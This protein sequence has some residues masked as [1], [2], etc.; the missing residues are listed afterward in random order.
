[1]KASAAPRRTLSSRLF[2]YDLF[3]SFALGPPPRGSRNYASDLARKL[4][5]RDFT[6]FFSED[7]APV[8]GKLDETLKRALH[9][10][11]V[12]VVVA[13]RGTL[14]NP[15]WV[16]QEVDEY[17]RRHPQRLVVPIN[18]D[19][20]LQDSQLAA[21]T[22]GWLPF[23]DRIWIDETAAAAEAGVASDEVVDRLVTAP[24]SVRAAVRWRWLVGAIIFFLAGLAAAAVWSALEA[25]R[26]RDMAV[27]RQLAVHAERAPTAQEAVLLAAESLHLRTFAETEALLRE[28]LALLPRV[29]HH[30][31]LPGA[32]PEGVAPLWPV[33]A[34]SPRGTY[35]AATKNG[36]PLHVIDVR[37]GRTVLRQFDNATRAQFSAGEDALAV[38][39]NSRQAWLVRLP[40][41]SARKIVDG[42]GEVAGF[43][44]SADGRRLLVG[45][46]TNYPDM[47]RQRNGFLVID[48]S[49]GERLASVRAGREVRRVALSPDGLTAYAEMYG[50]VAAWRAVDPVSGPDTL[51]KGVRQ[52]VPDPQ[53]P[54]VLLLDDQG[55]LQRVGAADPTEGRWNQTGVEAFV[56]SEDGDMLAAAM[57]GAVVVVSRRDGGFYERLGRPAGAPARSLQFL[58][59]GSLLRI[60]QTLYELPV[61]PDRPDRTE[62]RLA[63]TLLA[64]AATERVP[65]AWNP[66]GT[67][68]ATVE[69]PTGLPRI[70]F[71]QTRAGDEVARLRHPEVCRLQ[72]SRDGER[73]LSAGADGYARVWDWQRE[74]LIASVEHPFP[75]HAA[76]FAPDDASVV[77]LGP[78]GGRWWQASDAARLGG[79]DRE[80]PFM[81]CWSDPPASLAWVGH[82]PL[83][84]LPETL[85]RAA[86]V[87]VRNG[88][89]RTRL[90]HPAGSE[91][92]RDWYRLQALLAPDASE[93][94]TFNQNSPEPLLLHRLSDSAVVPLRLDPPDFPVGYLA[95]TDRHELVAWGRK[96]LDE[97]MSQRVWSLSSGRAASAAAGK[98]VSFT[99]DPR[100]LVRAVDNEAL[101]QS[102]FA[103]G[104]RA[105]ARSLDE[106]YLAVQ[107]GPDIRI[108][109]TRPEDLVQM[110][111]K[112]TLRAL[113]DDEWRRFM[114][115]VPPRPACVA[116]EK[117]SVR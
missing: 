60:D 115:T 45:L 41:G 53:G 102:L 11:G 117:T 46:Q 49:S 31:P 97:P 77:S 61:M 16:R 70:Q 82:D 24:S 47:G 17:R 64:L 100:G 58:A 6:V 93:A 40:D 104:R 9:R 67:L 95:F 27:A 109:S 78:R 103:H 68:L 90:Q 20:A 80:M 75:V 5:E 112:R 48:T 84:A 66:Q 59:G 1:M 19:G 94:V 65:S 3:I 25:I 33:W 7:E 8:G 92:A 55:Q 18:I 111:C 83:I 34:F 108:Y 87:E 88:T 76:W 96:L 69:A 50:E 86:I 38:S 63:P 74:R 28:K 44:F 21:A 73:L 10:A 42:E 51:G 107:V 110:A 106:R 62:A 30:V 105:F 52:W 2:G 85:D 89:M 99:A 22:E 98:P 37:S 39:N 43:S 72:F 81:S 79:F 114:G 91:P 12:L 32:T 101:Y 23:R 4:R 113:N 54:G 71:W 56:I 29:A 35:F 13:N 36:I 57:P 15:R 116:D 14:A 26:Q